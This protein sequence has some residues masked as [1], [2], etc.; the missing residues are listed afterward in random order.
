MEIFQQIL[1]WNQGNAVVGFENS[2]S[3]SW[4]SEARQKFI[5]ERMDDELLVQ[6]SYGRKRGHTE[7]H[8]VRDNLQWLSFTAEQDCI[9]TQHDQSSGEKL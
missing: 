7:M 3:D 5:D 8:D 6:N 1:Q 4:T 2:I 9:D